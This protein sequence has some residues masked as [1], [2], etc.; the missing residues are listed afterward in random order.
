MGTSSLLPALTGLWELE[1]AR[2]AKYK[3][4]T[5]S[6]SPGFGQKREVRVRNRA[7]CWT[8]KGI[9]YKPDHRHAEIIVRELG[10]ESAN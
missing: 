9:A 7:L 1:A 4:N 5:K 6:F 3:I 8:A 10:L 2:G